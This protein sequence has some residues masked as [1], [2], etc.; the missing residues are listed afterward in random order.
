MLVLP[1]LDALPA[2]PPLLEPATVLALPLVPPVPPWATALA[3]PP[4]LLNEV[5][6][7]PALAPECPAP[8]P[9]LLP[10]LTLALV[11]E[12]EQAFAV[13][14]KRPSSAKA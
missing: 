4:P 1:P 7:V 14:T 5:P 9:P 3:P 13:A 6:P 12:L 8:P 2:L 11:S 10:A